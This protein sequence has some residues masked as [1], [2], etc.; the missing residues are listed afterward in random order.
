LWARR[1]REEAAVRRWSRIVLFLAVLWS[2]AFAI[3]FF[4][5]EWRSPDLGRLR[6]QVEALSSRVTS[7]TATGAPIIELKRAPLTP[8]TEVSLGL[9]RIT[10]VGI[11]TQLDPPAKPGEARVEFILEGPHQGG[12]AFEFKVLDQD[13]FLCDSGINA[14]VGTPLGPG[15]KTRLWIYYKCA[16]GA[17]VDTLNLDGVMF[18]FPQP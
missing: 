3:S 17:R 16:E 18:E 2:G 8:G 10:V 11:T 5:T 15:E 9:A 13:G 6:A 14:E 7:P 12:L 4:V 1:A